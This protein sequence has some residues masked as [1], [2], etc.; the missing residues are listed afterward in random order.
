MRRKGFQAVEAKR[1]PGS[2][3]RGNEPDHP[4]ATQDAAQEFNKSMTSV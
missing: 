4:T 1:K 2:V 3:E